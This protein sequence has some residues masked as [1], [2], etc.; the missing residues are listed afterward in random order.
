M[1]YPRGWRQLLSLAPFV[2]HYRAQAQFLIENLSFGKSTPISSNGKDILGWHVASEGHTP[3]ILSDRITLTP[4]APGYARGAVWSENAV[5]Y[6]EWTVNMDFRASGPERAS[7]NLQIWFTRDQSPSVGLKSAYTVDTFDG[8]VLVLDQYAGSGGALRGFLNDGTVNFR[9][10]HNVDSLAFG[11]CDFVYR[12]LGRMSKLRMTQAADGL[13]VTVDDRPCF[14]SNLVNRFYVC[15]L[16]S[17]V[18][19]H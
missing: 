13:E 11:H 19:G 7:G 8:L 2:I 15:F 1:Y 5:N 9:N 10:H 12:N 14:K 4:P 16:S 6:A 3:Q 17:T 18:C